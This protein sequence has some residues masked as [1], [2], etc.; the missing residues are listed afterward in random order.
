M[1]RIAQF[2]ADHHGILNLASAYRV[3]IDRADIAFAARQGEIVRLHRGVYRFAGA[4]AT[5]E[6]ELL[7]ACWAAGSRGFASHRSAAALHALPGADRVVEITCPR[8]RRAH[9]DAIV[10][11]ESN[12][13]TSVDVV[14]VA[15]IPVASPA[16]TLLQLA[17]CVS[18]STL[19]LA[20]EQALRRELA[21]LESIDDVLRRYAKRGR[22]G[23]RM[24]RMLVRA[25]TPK[26]MPTDSSA[27]TRVL[28][29][30]RRH[31][32]A[33]PT[34]QFT[35]RRANGTKVGTVDLAYPDARIAIEYDSDEFHTGR[36]A[37]SHDSERR[38]RLIAAGWMPITAVSSDLRSGG[39]LLCGA[40]RAALTERRAR[41]AVPAPE[42]VT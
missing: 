5:W 2:A 38:H 33:E 29:V 4:P 30:I 9:H 13:W 8:W 40:L 28:Q 27:E 25:R 32:L 23:V 10:V 7:A 31:G 17:G 14:R 24:L 6:G 26:T 20:L 1:H 22:R 34:R 3:G 36:V 12:S 42:T 18:V 19:E 37:T 41:D 16:L 35:V 39:G 11:H 15:N 21:S